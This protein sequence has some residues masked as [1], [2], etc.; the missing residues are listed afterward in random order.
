MFKVTR[1]P[2]HV[3][4]LSSFNAIT[5]DAIYFKLRA[6]YEL[7]T[8]I[9]CLAGIY[10]FKFNHANTRTMLTRNILKVNNKNTRPTSRAYENTILKSAINENIPGHSRALF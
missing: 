3:N 5:S 1:T 10:W 7:E 9:Q 2:E 4:W 8:V 6:C